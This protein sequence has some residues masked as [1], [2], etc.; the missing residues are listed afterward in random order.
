MMLNSSGE[1][2]MRVFN[3]SIG[4]VEPIQSERI[5]GRTTARLQPKWAQLPIETKTATP[6][7]SKY[8]GFLGSSSILSRSRRMAKSR[9]TEALNDPQTSRYRSSS[10]PRSLYIR[11]AMSNPQ[12]CSVSSCSSQRRLMRLIV[13]FPI[14]IIGHTH[15]HGLSPQQS[16]Q[17]ETRS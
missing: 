14:K 3:C 10:K 16:C 5:G 17:I 4:S 8:C 2:A 12:S 1:S 7:I 13:L 11:N 6:T 15:I 9:P